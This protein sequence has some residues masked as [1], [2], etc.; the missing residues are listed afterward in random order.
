V[1]A[2]H[3]V[4]AKYSKVLKAMLQ[5]HM[6]ETENSVLYV[7]DINSQ[8]IQEF[9][10]FLYAG[11][12]SCRDVGSLLYVAEKYKVI[13]LKFQCIDHLH[14]ELKIA[15]AIDTL[16]IASKYN[17]KLLYNECLGLLYW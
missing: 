9:V 11:D 15:N 2:N 7:D 3:A 5:S 14:K 8:T 6:T 1:L 17:I 4:L 10:N 16:K 13:D 12:I